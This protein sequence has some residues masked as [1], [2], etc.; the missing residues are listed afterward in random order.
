MKMKNFYLI[1]CAA[2]LALCSCTKEINEEG[3]VDKANTIS[4]SA[5]SNKTR[6]VTG[7]VTSD[8]IKDDNFGV[9]GYFSNSLYL[10]ATDK[11]IEQEWNRTS[12]TWEYKTASDLKFWPNGSMDFYAYFPYSDHATFAE[13]NNASGAVMTIPGLVC[14]HDV[15]FAKHT[16]THIERVPLTFYHAFSKIKAVNVKVVPGNVADANVKVTVKKVEF[17]NTSTSGAVLVDKDGKASYSVAETNVTLKK[18]FESSVTISK[19]ETEG[20]SLIS[21]SDNC[22]LFA[23]SSTETN[24]VTGTGKT[25][26]DGTKESL[27]AGKLSVN[28]LVVLKLTCKVKDATHYYVGDDSRDGVVYIP[29]KGIDGSSNPVDAFHAGKRYIYNIQFSSNVGFTD[30]GDPI[31]KPILFKVDSVDNWDDVT[32]TITL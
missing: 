1:P 30:E 18:D 32:V 14:S 28:D 2:L 5:Y 21:D 25:M 3:F 23:T 17:I 24:N 27:S 8:N 12:G 26:W 15:L 16:T 31:L 10:G 6:A 29:L 4:F 11:A 7:D 9:V 13:A 19:T 20:V 22:Y